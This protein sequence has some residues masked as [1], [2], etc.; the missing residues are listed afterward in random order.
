LQLRHKVL[1]KSLHC[2]ELNPY[3]QLED[4]PFYVVQQTQ[5]WRRIQ[6]GQGQELPLRAGV[7]SF[8]FGGVNAHVVLEEYQ[9][10]VRSLRRAPGAGRAMVVLSAKNEERL[11]E[12]AKNL[13][14]QLRKQAFRE[15]DLWD[16][17][18]TL[19]VGRNAME[20]R[21]GMVVSSLSDLEQKIV[22]FLSDHAGGEGVYMGNTKQHRN[23]RAGRTA[24]S[25]DEE[26]VAQWRELGKEA[27][28][29]CLWVSGQ[30][31]DWSS[32][33]GEERL[34]RIS[35]PTYP[36]ATERYWKLAYD[37]H[38]SAHVSSDE[39]D[40]TRQLNDSLF[41]ELLCSLS[42]G[43]VTVDTAA[44]KIASALAS[45]SVD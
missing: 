6:D 13:L 4:S 21:L 23:G 26:N 7:S 34:Q 31:V 14:T 38:L 20:F 16:I 27:K 12:Q 17:A 15:T 29:I 44:L 24:K 22:A 43:T 39:T 37:S 9:G 32:L 5:P 11:K 18:Y 33:Y 42:K 28:S 30:P 36:F 25:G 45:Q 40:G 10:R 1:V 3:I 35:L 2:E 41:D 19:Q 8:G